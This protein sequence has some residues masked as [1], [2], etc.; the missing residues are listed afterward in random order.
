LNT[1]NTNRFSPPNVFWRP[2]YQLRSLPVKIRWE[3]TR[4]HPTYVTYWKLHVQSLDLPQDVEE[5]LTKDLEQLSRVFLA[6]IG[7]SGPTIDPSIEFDQLDEG[8]M[9]AAWL[10]GAVHP[11]TL[12]G[13]AGLLIAF[14]PKDVVGDVGIALM[15][16]C[17]E[18]KEGI[19]PYQSQAL[20]KL[21]QLEH[22]ALDSYPNEPIVSV[23][24]ASSARQVKDAL[25]SL[26]KSWKA[27]RGLSDQRDRSEK[28]EQY[29][30]IWDQ[31]EGWYQGFYHRTRERSL[32]EIA[33][34]KRLPIQTVHSQYK[35]AFELITGHE[36]SIDNWLAA[37]GLLKLS[38]LF[39]EI[40]T[41][42]KS[43]PLNP[44]T[45]RDIP[46]SVLNR[47]PDKRSIIEMNATDNEDAHILLINIRQ[48]I[49]DGKN[50]EEIVCE[51]GLDSTKLVEHIRARKTEGL[52]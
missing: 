20:G 34:E 19:E 40:G 31:R 23:N 52:F 6:A 1:P 22:E 3:V 9:N 8:S 29:L 5:Q 28:H 10:S 35:R 7:V 15:E 14:L 12:R 45:R 24:P 38:D 26:L 39:G 11:I 37:F 32:K 25:D 48:L 4:R 13:L 42:A 17:R 46:E 51:L 44:Q 33:Q 41:A 21:Y 49:A 47:N 50:D 2:E 27:E 16:A 18:D 43:R 30:D 36:Y